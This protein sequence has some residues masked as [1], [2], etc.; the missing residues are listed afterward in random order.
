MAGT[1]SAAVF[2]IVPFD[3]VM[4]GVFNAPVAPVGGKNALTVGLFRP[5]TGDAVGDFTGILTGFF[6]Y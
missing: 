3:D 6:I 5:S 4:A 2:V 1:Y